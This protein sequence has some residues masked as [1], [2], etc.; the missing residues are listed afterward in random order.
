MRRHPAPDLLLPFVAEPLTVEK[1][2]EFA[3]GKLASYKIRA[4]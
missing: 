3:A 1:L 2:R 4:T